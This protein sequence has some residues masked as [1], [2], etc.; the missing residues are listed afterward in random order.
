M[1]LLV[2]G[3]QGAFY[4]NPA[5]LT[6]LS[7]SRIQVLEEH[8][9]A[10]IAAE[11]A[12]TEAEWEAHMKQKYGESFDCRFESYSSP[13]ISPSSSSYPKRHSLASKK[14]VNSAIVRRKDRSMYTDL[15]IAFGRSCRRRG[16]RVR[17]WQGR[18]MGCK[19]NYFSS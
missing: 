5:D 15:W 7:P 9:R 17:N 13:T 2:Q 14:V 11:S 8:G 10:R 18:Q 6:K 3:Y 12:A 4:V 1:P 19:R 16:P